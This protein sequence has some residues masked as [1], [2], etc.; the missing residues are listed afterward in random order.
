[1]EQFDYN[2]YPLHQ[3]VNWL[4]FPLPYK[5]KKRANL[6]SLYKS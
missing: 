5:Q 4:T 3:L 2:I 6:G 1:M